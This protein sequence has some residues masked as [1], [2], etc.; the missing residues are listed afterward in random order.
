NKY[1]RVGSKYL[2]YVYKLYTDGN[3][4]QEIES[5]PSFGYV[6]PL[7]RVEVGEVMR[8]HFRN[9]VDMPVFLHPH[10]V[11]YTKSNEGLL[12]M[13]RVSARL[14]LYREFTDSTFTKEKVRSADEIHLG[15]MGPF[16][17]AEV[18]DTV[19]V[20]FKNMASRPYSIHAQGLRYNKT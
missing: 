20:V 9:D 5:P 10:G 18:G 4:T 14:A 11:K 15:V 12:I 16:I 19:E 17:K 8:I 6:G 2:K 1:N 7:L 3:F 13:Q